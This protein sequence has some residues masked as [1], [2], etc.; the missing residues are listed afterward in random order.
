[1]LVRNAG[2][3]TYCVDHAVP[4]VVDFSLNAANPLTVD[5]LMRMARCG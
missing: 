4:F 1:M 5:L 2:G 3:L